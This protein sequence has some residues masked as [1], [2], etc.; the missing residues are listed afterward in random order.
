MIHSRR[1]LPRK[2]ESTKRT[3]VFRVFVFSWLCLV[4][5]GRVAAGADQYGRVTF[6]DQ[7]VPGA[8]LTATRGDV[9]RVTVTDGQGVFRFADLTDGPWTLQIEMLG[10]S[11]LREEVVVSSGAQPLSVCA[12]AAAVRNDRLER[13]AAC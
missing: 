4:L 3:E 12:D 13:C 5:L 1:G 6:S 8:T 10:F 9:A 2:H 11:T 7:P